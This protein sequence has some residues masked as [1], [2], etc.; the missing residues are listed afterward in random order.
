[1]PLEPHLHGITELAPYPRRHL[2]GSLAAIAAAGALPNV[3]AAQDA[4]PASSPSASPVAS[5]AA[6]GEWT[7]TDDRGVTVTLPNRPQ[8]IVADLSAAAPLWDF[9]VRPLAVSGWTIAT[10]AAW[11][12][13]D[14]STRIINASETTPD[15]DNEALVELEP[16]LFVSITWNPEDP[17]TLWSFS[18]ADS[19]ITT[20]SIVPIVA[21]SATGSAEA[22]MNRFAELAALLGVDLNAPDLVAA[23][24]AYDASVNAFSAIS[25]QRSD[26][27]VLFGYVGTDPEWYAAY[28]SDWAD[29][30]WYRTLG[31]NMIDVVAVAGDYWE[32]LSFEQALL[33]PSD[34]IFLS[35]RSGTLSI[36]ELQ[37]HPTFGLHPAIAGNQVGAWN[38]DFIMSYQGLTSALDNMTAI[39]TTAEKLTS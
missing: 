29:L 39:L 6:D 17:T 12:N 33:Y 22:N 18:D 15:P 13:V 27:S 1:S 21:I 30:A 32:T 19:L 25:A 2:V 14:R 31:L 24:D 7:F 11:G 26:L 23:K 37:A 36:E 5:P 38:Q 28:T 10:D 16:D 34:V 3:L 4:S 20:E 8:R 9:G 35:T